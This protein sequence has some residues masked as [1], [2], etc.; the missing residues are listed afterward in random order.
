MSQQNSG[1]SDNTVIIVGVIFAVLA[2][3]IIYTNFD[4]IVLLWKSIRLI[5]MAVPFAIFSILPDS[6]DVKQFQQAYIWLI[7][8]SST[9]IKFDTMTEFDNYY[10]P[11]VSWIPACL[12][13]WL[14]FKKIFGTSNFTRRHSIDSLLKTSK[15]IH[16]HLYR[17][18]DENPADFPLVYSRNSNSKH[19][20]GISPVDFA[21]MTPPM[22]LEEAAKKDSSL[23]KSIWTLNSGSSLFDDSL[24]EKAFSAQLGSRYT[25]IN[26]LK[27]YE[28]RLMRE[29]TKKIKYSIEEASDLIT[30][31]VKGSALS[32]ASKT[33]YKFPKN[34]LEVKKAF[35]AKLQ[36]ILEDK[37]NKEVEK[38]G[39]SKK[40]PVKYADVFSE[41][42]IKLLALDESLHKELKDEINDVIAEQIMLEH[43]YFR[44]GV[45]S[46][47]ERVRS[48]GVF[49]STEVEWVKDC[50]DRTLVYTISSAGRRVA[51]TEAAG[52][53]AHYLL[54]KELGRAVTHPE[55]YEAV[56]GLKLA[57]KIDDLATNIG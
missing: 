36:K 35:Q 48:S 44:T 25:G 53:F 50:D 24:A 17:Y 51:F 23:N 45:F 54:E 20:M 19:A 6:Y 33:P 5:E 49:A 37:F 18:L 22:L 52:V 34:T 4:K 42:K 1:A 40:S 38:G 32:I 11:W 13:I 41:A 3:I 8:R 56:E 46:L 9:E 57:L 16:K 2:T 55:V 21:L 7:E 29:L 10:V 26:S 28:Q 47:I 30:E 43:A 12:F 15:D 14:G 31:F 39:R 27:D